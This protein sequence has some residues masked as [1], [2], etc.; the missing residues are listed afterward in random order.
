MPTSERCSRRLVRTI[1]LTVTA[2]GGL[3]IPTASA[4]ALALAPASAAT[5]QNCAIVIDRLQPG[6]S[7]S[8]IVSKTCSPAGTGPALP[9]GIQAADLIVTFYGDVGYGGTSSQVFG[10]D[11]PCD[12]DGY[13]INN[14]DD[15]N[16]EVGLASSY[17]LAGTCT[18]SEMYT[19]YDAEGTSSGLIFGQ[20]QSYVGATFNDNINSFYMFSS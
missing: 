7:S 12:A 11:G 10:D 1:I 19:G 6:E 8:Q 16:D 15:V 17:R 5:D 14:M 3:V 13:G 2:I 9:A 20:D 4:V 18:I